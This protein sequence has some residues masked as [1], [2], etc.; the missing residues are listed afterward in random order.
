MKSV[1]EKLESLGHSKGSPVFSAVMDAVASISVHQ[2]SELQESEVLSLISPQ[3]MFELVDTPLFS[4]DAWMEFDYGNAKPGDYVRVEPDAYD[5]VTGVNHNSRVG[6]LLYVKARRC[7][8]R[9]IGINSTSTMH[10]PIGK[11]Q[12]LKYGV[13]WKTTQK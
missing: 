11:L 4:D 2:L 1:A 8:V 6:V 7:T 5:S 9:Y 12:S 3:G 10:H 13:Q